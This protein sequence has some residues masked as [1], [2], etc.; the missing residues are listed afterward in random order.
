MDNDKYLVI[1][2]T[3]PAFVLPIME[4]VI[5]SCLEEYYP[6][7]QYMGNVVKFDS[8]K[9]YDEMSDIQVKIEFRN[10][11]ELLAFIIAEEKRFHARIA[12]EVSRV[13]RN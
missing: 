5:Q 13:L 3:L 7:N 11:A 9:I 12:S 4:T 2:S 6:D 8:S 10:N 1:K